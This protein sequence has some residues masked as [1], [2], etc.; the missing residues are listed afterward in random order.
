MVEASDH[1]LQT[2]AKLLSLSHGIRLAVRGTPRELSFGD[3]P[4]SRG[5][6]PFPTADAVAALIGPCKGLTKLTFR[7][8]GTP[9]V[10]GC[11][12]TEAA[13]AGWVDEAFGGHDR[14]VV[15]ESPPA[16]EP[17]LAR[18]LLRLPGLLEL[19]LGTR[20]K[21]SA[22]L[23]AVIAASCPH[24][25]VLRTGS[26]HTTSPS[27]DL[28]GLAPLAGSLQEFDMPCLCPS[29]DVD[30]FVGSLS[31]VGTLHI[32]HCTR[33][34]LEPIAAHLTDLSVGL[35]DDLPEALSTAGLAKLLAAHPATMQRLIL[36]LIK[37]TPGG[38]T[39]LMSA[40]DALPRLTHLCLRTRR[41]LLPGV[42]IT[43]LPARLLGRLE[44]LCLQL[45]ND[46]EDDEAVR[47]TALRPL[48]FASGRLKCLDIKDLGRVSGLTVDCPALAELRL[49][50]VPA[51]SPLSLKCP[52]LRVAQNLPAWFPGFAGPMPQL[53]TVFFVD[54]KGRDPVCLADLLAGG[55][56]RLHNL[57]GVVLHRPDLL[58]RL[59]ACDTLVDLSLV[60]DE[61]RQLPN[62]L[63]LR[64]PPQLQSMKDNRYQSHDPQTIP[65][66]SRFR[67]VARIVLFLSSD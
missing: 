53:E 6:M 36:V 51:G 33:A 39:A 43:A 60:L 63:V 13:C 1:A 29:P 48:S 67:S 32:A 31:A 23:L 66:I 8:E 58:S 64:L 26:K 24:L 21:I 9:N 44:D 14:L 12:C 17:V 62:P 41:A 47:S 45:D 37:P 49:P 5:E 46:P 25:R 22:H 40:L 42:D 57:Y 65:L 7:S 16:S 56:P 19:R 35:V 54:S 10:Y 27:M 28:T 3:N 38:M 2:Y 15:L 59:C 30:A 55:S 50:E 18:I 20:P 11:G 34:A 52:Q 4:K 61:A